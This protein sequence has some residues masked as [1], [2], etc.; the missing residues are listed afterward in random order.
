M[1]SSRVTAT[2]VTPGFKSIPAM[3]KSFVYRNAIAREKGK[4]GIHSSPGCG[5]AE[6]ANSKYRHTYPA[7]EKTAVWGNV[8]WFRL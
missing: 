7:T 8:N 6:K 1:P 5:C 2:V 3:D 4:H